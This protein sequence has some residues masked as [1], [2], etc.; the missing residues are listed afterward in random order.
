MAQDP[1]KPAIPETE[2][3]K[4]PEEPEA[5]VWQEMD[6]LFRQQLEITAPMSR[7]QEELEDAAQASLAL[8]SYLP[9]T[10]SHVL[11]LPF[12]QGMSK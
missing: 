2:R 6:P 3:S 11:P 1:T 10:A 12:F 7:S 5:L 4:S 8:D 9:Y